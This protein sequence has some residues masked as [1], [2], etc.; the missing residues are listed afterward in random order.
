MT[1]KFMQ[2]MRSDPLTFANQ[3]HFEL[4]NCELGEDMYLRL[5]EYDLERIGLGEFPRY[6]CNMP[7][8]HAKTFLFCVTLPA[9]ILV[10]NPSARILIVS[11]GEDPA[12]EISRK[13]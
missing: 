12:T 3:A 4:H 1:N 2:L 13:I 7:P 8:G 9:W 6:V 10:H 11:Y 5:L